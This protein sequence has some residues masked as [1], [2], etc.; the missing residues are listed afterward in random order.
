MPTNFLTIQPYLAT[1]APKNQKM[2]FSTTSRPDVNMLA[3]FCSFWDQ[4][5]SQITSYAWILK[6]KDPAKKLAQNLIL[7]KKLGGG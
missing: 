3:E 4:I 5:L 2:P 7:V 1:G 6:T